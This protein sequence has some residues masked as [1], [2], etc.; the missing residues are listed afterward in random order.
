MRQSHMIVKT[1]YICLIFIF[2][3]AIP[4]LGVSGDPKGPGF[5]KQEQ[6]FHY[7]NVYKPDM[8]WSDI[9]GESITI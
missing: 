5:W 4:C 7:W 6:N 9:F 1:I 3:S 8:K 2:S